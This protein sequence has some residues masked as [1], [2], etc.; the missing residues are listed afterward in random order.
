MRCKESR[1]RSGQ[2]HISAH[3]HSR[4][5]PAH[6]GFARIFMLKVCEARLFLPPHAPNICF[7]GLGYLFEGATI[8]MKEGT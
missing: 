5:F 8:V 7:I 4:P 6:R 2:G 3:N 1:L